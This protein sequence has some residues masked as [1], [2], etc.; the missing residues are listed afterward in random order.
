MHIFPSLLSK[1]TLKRVLTILISFDSND[2]YLVYTRKYIQY[3]IDTITYCK[4]TVLPQVQFWHTSCREHSIH[5]YSV[6]SR[7]L[8]CGTI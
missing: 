6:L 1:R 2:P 8:V 3:V 5:V 7:T 4:S